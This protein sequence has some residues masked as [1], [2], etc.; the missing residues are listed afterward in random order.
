MPPT[1][2]PRPRRRSP[3]RGWLI[4][5]SVLLGLSLPSAPAPA[6]AA[7]TVAAAGTADQHRHRPGTTTVRQVGTAQVRVYTP[8][9]YRP[10]R[11]HP[12]VVMVHGCNTNAAEQQAASAFERVAD[13]HGFVVLFADHDQRENES[14][15]THPVRCW[16]FYSPADTHRGIGDPA[17]VVAQ[18]RAVRRDW[19]INRNRVYVVGM[20]SGG[21]M[22]SVLGATY[23]DVYAAIGVVAGCGYGA[24][25]ACLLEAYHDADPSS[26]EAQAAHREQADRARAVPMIG[27]HG[28]ADDLIPPAAGP[29][30]VRQW[31]KTAN[32]ALSGT[33]RRPVRLRPTSVRVVRPQRRRD[34]QVADYRDRRTD[35]LMARRVTVRGMGHYWPGGSADPSVAEW[36]DH[37]APG[38]AAL[39]WDFFSRHR[40]GDTTRP[41]TSPSCSAAHEPGAADHDSDRLRHRG[42]GVGHG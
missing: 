36:T 15:G 27:I 33:E 22:T 32:L 3:H 41:G 11:R 37:T 25:A 14:L 8:R 21:M 9:T 26:L 40:L 4:A 30:T 42:R 34:Y 1:T 13:R 23:P 35:C 5:L 17:D 19:S 10:G 31:V 38:G 29:G 24:G 12:L 39:V 2:H 18:T 7:H 20:S 28:D 16:R 6:P